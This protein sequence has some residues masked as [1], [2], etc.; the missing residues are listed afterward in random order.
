MLLAYETILSEGGHV[1]AYTSEEEPEHKKSFKN[2]VFFGGASSTSKVLA[3]EDVAITSLKE[4][5]MG[6]WN[7]ADL[8]HWLTGVLEARPAAD[9]VADKE[10]RRSLHS[11]LVEALVHHVDSVRRLA[12]SGVGAGG[13]GREAGCNKR[14]YPGATPSFFG[15][16]TM[17]HRNKKFYVGSGVGGGGGDSQRPAPGADRSAVAQAGSVMT[18]GQTFMR[19]NLEAVLVGHAKATG[20]A[21]ECVNKAVA[22]IRSALKTR[23]V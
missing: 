14:K 20:V 13:D 10:T 16:T 12:G 17:S 23:S 1:E 21:V 6:R 22:V 5:P 18:S 4:S 7:R 3:A 9:D 15:S 11:S 2:L 19:I 8:R